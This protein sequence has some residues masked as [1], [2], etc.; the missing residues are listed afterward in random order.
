ML[1]SKNHVRKLVFMGEVLQELFFSVSNC[2]WIVYFIET[3]KDVIRIRVVTDVESY[4][5]PLILSEKEMH[6]CIRKLNKIQ[7]IPMD[8]NVIHMVIAGAAS[9]SMK[10]PL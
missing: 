7:W 10:N 9:Y 4:D 3:R 5:I 6:S 1:L 8:S 2:S